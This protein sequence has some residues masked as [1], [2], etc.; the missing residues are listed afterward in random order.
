MISCVRYRKRLGACLDGELSL[1]EQA[2]FQRHLAKCGSCR[3][4]LDGLRKLGPL[5]LPLDVPPAPA[6]LTSR[7]LAEAH[8]RQMRRSVVNP[9]WS[10]WDA[11]TPQSW[12]LRGATTAALIGGLTMGAFMGLTTYR[13]GRMTQLSTAK[14]GSERAEN[15]LYDLDILSGVPKGSIESAVLALLEDRR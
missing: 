8:T 4:A 9:R 1:R 5:L 10:W 12:A 3:T 11:L 2:S 7:I 13:D 6:T 14:P 15:P